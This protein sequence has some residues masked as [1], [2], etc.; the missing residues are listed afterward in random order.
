MELKTILI[1]LIITFTLLIDNNIIN[2]ANHNIAN[3]D[4]ENTPNPF[5]TA[6]TYTAHLITTSRSRLC[7][8]CT[9]SG[10]HYYN[11]DPNKQYG[12]VQWF[13]GATNDTTKSTYIN[14]GDIFMGKKQKMFLVQD[15]GGKGD[16]SK[17]TCTLIT[18]YKNPIFNNSWSEEAKYV[19]NV[20][21][22]NELC[23]KFANVYPYFIQGEVYPG[24]YYESIFT[25][26]PKGFVNGKIKMF[27]HIHIHTHT[28]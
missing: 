13:Y 25:G 20:F 12:H 27:T 16:D 7:P 9:F 5:P 21:F 6:A 23:K 2:A 18:P 24:F 3:R 28:Y 4:S 1:L 10:K 26:L 22:K 17:A 8:Q 14:F 15:G 11:A 19:G